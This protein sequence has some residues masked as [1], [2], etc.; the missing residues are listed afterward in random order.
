MTSE[1]Q[2][3]RIAWSARAALTFGLAVFLA[4]AG[5]P[6]RAQSLADV[7]RVEEARRR[8]ITRPSRVYTNK[9]LVSVP[10]PEPA[11]PAAQ[12]DASKEKP[13]ARDE[14]APADAAIK[15]TQAD[16][17]KEKPKDQAY[18]AG[19]MKDL[20]AQLERDKVLSDAMQSRIN[21]LTTDFTSRDDPIQRAKIGSDRQRALEELERLK[22]AIAN[23]Q[24]AIADLQEEA[25]RAAVPPGWLR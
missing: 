13:A 16:A 21:A 12:A 24:K 2:M 7:A 20:L 3:M 15:E 10:G 22:K 5:V 6:I 1:T 8:E 14:K 9:D 17:S 4:P 11:P 25:R 18:W 19:R 23:D